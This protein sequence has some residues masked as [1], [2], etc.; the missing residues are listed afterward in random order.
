MASRRGKS[1]QGQ[2]RENTGLLLQ[3]LPVGFTGELDTVDLVKHLIAQYEG[4]R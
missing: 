1:D 3:N 4:T 2:G